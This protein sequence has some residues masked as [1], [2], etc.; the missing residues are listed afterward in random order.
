[1][2]LPR[3]A[4]YFAIR[5]QPFVIVTRLRRQ[6]LRNSLNFL[7]PCHH[8]WHLAA[9]CREDPFPTPILRIV[10]VL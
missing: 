2:C 3:L 7:N 6:L 5:L 1:M 4:I 8:L 10:D 9:L